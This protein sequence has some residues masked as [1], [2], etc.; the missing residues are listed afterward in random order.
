MY[1]KITEELKKWKFDFK[2][3]LMLIGAKQ[4]GK[5]YILN[6]FC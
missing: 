5:T 6:E 3:A 2:R 1:R 4:S